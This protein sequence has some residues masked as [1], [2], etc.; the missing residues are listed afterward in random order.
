[1]PEEP[2]ERGSGPESLSPAVLIER[3]P[4]AET[5]PVAPDSPEPLIFPTT[6]Q[7]RALLTSDA[8]TAAAKQAYATPA[9]FES[10]PPHFF[11]AVISRG[12]VDSYDTVMHRSTL[13]N[14]AQD[15]TDGVSFQ[16]SHNT[17]E[18]GFGRSLQGEYTGG[19][20]ARTEAAFYT[21]P[22][23]KMGQCSTDDLILGMGTGLVRDVSVGFYGGSIRCS[24]C[25]RDIYSYECSHWPGHT[26]DADGKR[27]DDGEMAVGM[28]HDAH[29]AEVSAV[30]DGS[31]PGAM[32][33]K[34][35][36]RAE[37]GELPGAVARLLEVRYRVKLPGSARR[38]AG[39]DVKEKPMPDEPTPAET[40]PAAPPVTFGAPQLRALMEAAGL[41]PLESEELNLRALTDTLKKLPEYLTERERLAKLADYGTKYHAALVD[42][43]I[44]EGVRA[45]GAENFPVEERK[46]KLERQSIE[47][48]QADLGLW[49]KTAAALF[50]GGRQTA[51]VGEP[52]PSAATRGF[53]TPPANPAHFRA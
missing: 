7:V 30:Y 17:R 9:L 28:V 45:F 31:C 4:P 18:L 8:L 10:H 34:A 14:F 48:I 5:P 52:D 32:I 13:E 41:K 37:A 36:Q 16:N 27:A 12:V 51:D 19:Q 46:L 53:V 25:Q 6:A 50:Q 33:V 22:G 21:V 35:R 24:V 29:L 20:N 1:M 3:A 47:D 11:R 23:L 38:F 2:T 43:A 39:A 42:E 26:Y 15:A 44:T 49:R 40:A